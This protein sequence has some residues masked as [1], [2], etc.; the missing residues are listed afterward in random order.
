MNPTPDRREF[1]HQVAGSLAA[2][3]L[4]P[5]LLPSAPRNVGAAPLPVA[6]IGAGKQGKQILTELL[7]FDAAKVVAV[8]DLRDER[9]KQALRRA[10]GAAS[11]TDHRA[12][13][14]Q[15]KEV[16]AVFVATPT[17]RHRDVVI[18]CLKAGRHV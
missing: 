5:E 1:L 3:A 14:D 2:F 13:L 7:K 18:D 9:N 11:F 16:A 6:L 8:C 4:A 17:H 10:A 15:Q 12:L